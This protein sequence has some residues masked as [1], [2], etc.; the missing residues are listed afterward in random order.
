MSTYCNTHIH[1]RICARGSERACM[2]AS[3]PAHG[4]ERAW[5]WASGPAH[6]S[7]RAQPRAFG[8]ALF[9]K[10]VFDNDFSIISDK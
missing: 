8:P 4:S 2:W 6:G 1:T 10:C 9:N 3:G 5:M 7:E